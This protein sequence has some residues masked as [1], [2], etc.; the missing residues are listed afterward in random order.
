MKLKKYLQHPVQKHAVNQESVEKLVEEW[1][2]INL[3]GI[4]DGVIPEKIEKEE[5]E[6]L[7]NW[8]IYYSDM[9]GGIWSV[10]IHSVGTPDVQ[11]K[12]YIFWEKP[13]EEQ[14]KR[15]KRVGNGQIL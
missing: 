5:V 14:L 11:W 7:E 8:R 1:E 13:N 12:T 3:I 2:K 6:E 10:E 4:H 15:A 9:K